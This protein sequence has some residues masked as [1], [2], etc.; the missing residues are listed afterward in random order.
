MTDV[1]VACWRGVCLC[2][3]D[4]C[5]RNGC[6]AEGV[7]QHVAAAAGDG[8]FP[9]AHKCA[10]EGV[11]GSNI[12]FLLT[13]CAATDSPR[14]RDWQTERRGGRVCVAKPE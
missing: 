11:I 5:N 9:C 2:V 14:S 7:E 13:P 4:N 3:C 12:R 1:C 10:K 8:E 6:G